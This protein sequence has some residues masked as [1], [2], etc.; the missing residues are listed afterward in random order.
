[1]SEP[2]S[3]LFFQLPISGKPFAWRN[4]DWIKVDRNH[5]ELVGG[6]EVAHV[7][8]YDHVIPQCVPPDAAVEELS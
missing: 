1:M 8:P 4:Q 5:A 2:E 3:V 6:N 7:P